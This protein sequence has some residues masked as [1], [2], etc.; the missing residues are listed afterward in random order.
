MQAV[1][2][3]WDGNQVAVHV[4]GTLSTDIDERVP[5]GLIDPKTRP[6]TVYNFRKPDEISA[7]ALI[8]GQQGVS[9]SSKVIDNSTRKILGTVGNLLTQSKHVTL[10]ALATAEDYQTLKKG[11]LVH[12][13]DGT[14]A[15]PRHHTKRFRA[16][17]NRN[18]IGYFFELENSAIVIDTIGGGM[19]VTRYEFGQLKFSKVCIQQPS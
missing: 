6:A 19:I 1:K 18:F 11:D 14:V 10:N 9:L 13:S 4:D 3:Q 12:A 16:W 8:I 7:F 17:E 15:P 2:S 5:A